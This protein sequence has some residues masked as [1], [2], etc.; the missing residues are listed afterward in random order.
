[1]PTANPAFS[2]GTRSYAWIAILACVTVALSL[3]LA[4][5]VP[6]AAL[7][8]VAALT[9]TR[10]DALLLVGLAWLANQA[11]GFGLLHY[12][13]TA[14][15]LA[16]GLVLLVVSVHATLGAGLCATRFAALPRI[17]SAIFV[18]LSAFVIYEGLLFLTAITFDS[19]VAD[20]APAII[21]WVFAVN[22]LACA[23][24]LAASRLRLPR[25]RQEPAPFR[26]AA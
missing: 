21:A 10:R 5:A 26:S 15:T 9:L 17:G 1:M 7:A 14:D 24:L 18:F 2:L 13:W 6:F 12:P 8:A 20:F 19:G 22:A 23:G 3:A 11:V 4:C 16:W 25:S